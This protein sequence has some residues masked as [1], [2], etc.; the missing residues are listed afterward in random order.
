MSKERLSIQRKRSARVAAVQGVYQSLV[1]DEAI[2]AA[3]RAPR[4]IAQWKSETDKE[5]PEWQADAEPEQALLMKLLEGVE[6]HK[7]AL[8]E[9]IEGSLREGWKLSRIAPITHAILLCAVYELAHH[10][11]LNEGVIVNEYVTMAG[12]FVDAADIDY[13]HAT[14]RSLATSLRGEVAQK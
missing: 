7:V 9:H 5:E 3:K 11:A 4:L 14:L 1:L 13:I 8:D 10:E 12:A 2:A 6:A